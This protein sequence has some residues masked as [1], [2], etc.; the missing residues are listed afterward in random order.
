MRDIEHETAPADS[1]KWPHPDDTDY[2]QNY[3]RALP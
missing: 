3:K 2:N 1:G